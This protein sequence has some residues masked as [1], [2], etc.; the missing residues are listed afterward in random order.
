MGDYY[1]ISIIE[2][3]KP[4]HY[5][6]DDSAQRYSDEVYFKINTPEP[7]YEQLICRDRHR[8]TRNRYAFVH[9]DKHFNNLQNIL[10][11]LKQR[12][13]IYGDVVL[14]MTTETHD[15]I[16]NMIET[17]FDQAVTIFKGALST[18][19]ELLYNY[20]EDYGSLLSEGHSYDFENEDELRKKVAMD[21]FTSLMS[22][23]KICKSAKRRIHSSPF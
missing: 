1:Y 15:I 11:Y 19:S 13:D 12:A 22:K 10:D 5:D 2:K 16:I 21:R 18:H 4:G 20:T 9:N 14:D 7:T 23:S 6:I 8:R 17:T 3:Q